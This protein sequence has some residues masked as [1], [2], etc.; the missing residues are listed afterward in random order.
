MDRGQFGQG[1][2]WADL[3]STIVKEI[4]LM[5]ELDKQCGDMSARSRSRFLLEGRFRYE[6]RSSGK[7]GLSRRWTKATLFAQNVR[8]DLRRWEPIQHRVFWIT[9]L[10]E[11]KSW[12]MLQVYIM[13]GRPKVAD[14]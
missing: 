11:S 2:S 3:S 6:W 1:Y 12:A 8:W 10:L 5:S 9:L 14:G 7:V 13:A 4:L